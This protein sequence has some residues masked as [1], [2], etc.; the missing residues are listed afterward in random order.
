MKKSTV[1]LNV[2]NLEMRMAPATWGN[3]WPDAA[4]LT[5]SFVPDGTQVGNH[6]SNL[7]QAL[8]SQL[9]TSNVAAWEQ[10][11]LRAFQT[12]AVNANIN[13]SVVPDGGQPIGT[14]GAFQG[15]ARFG[16]IRVAAFPMSPD[17]MMQSDD[18]LAISEPFDP[19]AGTW[20][21][22]VILNTAYTFGSDTKN[23]YDLFTVALHEA[24]HVLGFDHSPN[25][26]DAMYK[27]YL[28]TRTGLSSN[29]IAR[30][31]T[32]YAPRPTDS[33]TSFSS[34]TTLVAPLSGSAPVTNGNISS[35][36]DGD[37]YK[38]TVPIISLGGV[39]VQL[40]TSG[41]SSLLS[42]VT[43]FD[44][45]YHFVQ[46]VVATDPTH[47]DLSVSLPGNLLT[48]KTYYIKVESATSDVFGIGAYQIRAVNSATGIP[49]TDWLLNTVDGV[50]NSLLTA[51]RLTQT[52]PTTD[53]RFDYTYQSNINSSS[54]TDYFTFNSP[55]PPTGFA[56]VMTAYVWG[57][58]NRSLDPSITLLDS[59]G[60]AIP[61]NVLVH[62]NGSMVI[63]FAPEPGSQQYYVRIAAANPNGPNNVGKY[64]L[65]IDF[66]TVITPVPALTS[67]TANPG[68]TTTAFTLNVGEDLVGHF[69]LSAGASG[70]PNAGVQMTIYDQK[71]NVVYTLSAMAGDTRSLTG[72]LAA[73]T[74]TIKFKSFTTDD[75]APPLIGYALRGLDV[76]DPISP[77]PQKDTT[78]GSGGTSGGGTTTSSS[79]GSG[80]SVMW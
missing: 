14:T 36:T 65:G 17:Q 71:G 47:G 7:T 34:A 29:D 78:T 68:G 27:D 50:G 49:L 75:S 19:N 77:Y 6:Q 57:L 18:P 30:L 22:D 52:T 32:L 45:S 33:S 21:G 40:K 39:T 70:N 28:G 66:S 61:T 74:Y 8:N 54:D 51:L 64:F 46:S 25:I 41:V 56:N 9:K 59:D 16:D 31:Q 76:S 80:S 24:G 3:P 69:I 15:D 13:V 26:A 73:G 48:S 35:L 79:S 11:I 42:R 20:T 10:T 23:T 55:T 53:S 44:S 38:V 12:W 5:L 67:G 63:Q 1:R 4:H 58:D 62:E 60:N 72:F 43:V 37:F 2:E